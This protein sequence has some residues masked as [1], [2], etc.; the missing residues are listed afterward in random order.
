MFYRRQTGINIEPKITPIAVIKVA[1]TAHPPPDPQDPGLILPI[2]HFRH[3]TIPSNLNPN[4]L[5]KLK[6]TGPFKE[7]EIIPGKKGEIIG[8]TQ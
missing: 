1:I 8:G 3:L 4:P 7:R 5:K 6:E 2:A